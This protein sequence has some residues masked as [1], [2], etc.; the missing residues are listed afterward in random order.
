M[1]AKEGL[2]SRDLDNLYSTIGNPFLAAYQTL[3]VTD[4][5]DTYPTPVPRVLL[6]VH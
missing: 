2:C 6:P 1:T 4:R 5:L 3:T